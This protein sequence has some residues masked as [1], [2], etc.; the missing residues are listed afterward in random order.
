M[1]IFKN[2]IKKQKEA[3]MLSTKKGMVDHVM[4][5]MAPEEK[6]MED[7]EEEG[8]E[9]EIELPKKPSSEAKIQIDLLLVGGKKKKA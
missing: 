1:S 5:T 7:K 6:E 9:I 8:D 4:K 3:E 2:I